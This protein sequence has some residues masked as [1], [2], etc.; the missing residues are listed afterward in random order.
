VTQPIHFFHFTDLHIRTYANDDLAS[1]NTYN[2][3]MLCIEAA[4]QSEIKPAFSLLTGDLSD[5]GS[6]ESYQR[7][8]EIVRQLEALGGPVFV[9]PGNHDS[10]SNFQQHLLNEA[11]DEDRPHYE[12]HQFGSLKVIVLDSKLPH[13]TV[14]GGFEE[15]QLD[16]LRNELSQK[17]AQDVLLAFHHPLTPLRHAITDRILMRE[18]DSERLLDIIHPYQIVGILAGHVHAPITNVLRGIPCITGIAT[19]F[20]SDHEAGYIRFI[21]ASGFNVCT[22]VEQVLTVCTVTLPSSNRE[23]QRISLQKVLEYLQ[24]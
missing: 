12:C 19:A 20:R 17:P 14:Y 6:P 4:R 3:M 23:I 18:G 21:D 9:T 10:R 22:Y 5:D 11:A 24:A 8:R 2:R 13:K 1:Y 7:L 16:W 15:A